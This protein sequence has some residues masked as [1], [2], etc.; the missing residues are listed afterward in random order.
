MAKAIESLTHAPSDASAHHSGR[1]GAEQAAP[2]EKKDRGA[3]EGRDAAVP[4]ADHQDPADTSEDQVVTSRRAAAG[5]DA[6]LPKAGLALSGGGVRSATF[7]FGL[8][9]AL[10]ANGVLQRFDYLSTV[11]GGGYAGAM[12]GRLFA[13]GASADEVARGLASDGS[14]LL[15]WLR[16]NGRYLIPSGLADMLQAGASQLRGFIATQFEASVVAL[17]VAALI[18]LPHLLMLALGWVGIASQWLQ[19]L[20]TLWWAA[21]PLP[22]CA[23]A[24]AIFTY[25]FSRDADDTGARDGLVAMG[26]SALAVLLAWRIGFPWRTEALSGTLVLLMGVAVLLACVPIAYLIRLCARG[27]PATARVVYTRWLARSLATIIA[28]LAFG[29]ADL[30]TWLAA[31]LWLYADQLDLSTGTGIVAVVVIVARAVLPVL[32]NR[33]LAGGGKLPL[34]KLANIAGLLLAALLALIWLT[35]LQ[36]FIFLAENSLAL[37]ALLAQ[38]SAVP[39]ARWIL[40]F[41]LLA[42][43]AVATL[44]NLAQLNRSSAHEFYRSRLARTYVSVGNYSGGG[45]GGDTDATARARFPASTLTDATGE[46]ADQT[47]RVTELLAGDDVTLGNYLPHRAG[48]PLHLVNCCIN[49][50]RDDR[51]GNYNADRKGIA[52]TV[53]ALGLETGTHFPMAAMALEKSALN[54]MS[55]AS[56]IA[57]SGAAASSGMGSST[58]PGTS[59]L[60]FL[61]GLRLGYW[62]QREP[63]RQ[64]GKYRALLSELFARFPGLKSKAWYL[65][66]GGHF[67]NTGVYALLK[68]RLPLIVLADC[69]ADPRYLFADLEN[70]VRKARLDY[71]AHIDFI[72]PS[73]LTHPGLRPL[74]GTPE[75]IGPDVGGAHLLLGRIRY[76]SGKLGALLVVKPRRLPDLPLDIV[77]YADRDPVFPQQTTGDQFFDEAQWESYQALGRLLG[78][79]ITP[80]LLAALPAWVAS[81]PATRIGSVAPGPTQAPPPSRRARLATTLGTSI[82]IGAIASM[83]LA[84][85]QLWGEHNRAAAEHQT[86][87]LD[88]STKTVQTIA[89]AQSVF[90][91][92]VRLQIDALLNLAATAPG[93][94]RARRRTLVMLADL[95]APVCTSQTASQDIFQNTPQSTGVCT[96]YLQALRGEQVE[97]GVLRKAVARYWA[98]PSAGPSKPQ[99]AA[100]LDIIG[101]MK[102][103]ILGAFE[104]RYTLL[105]APPPAGGPPAEQQ[106]AAPGVD[107]QRESSAQPSPQVACR[108]SA[109]TGLSL[110]IHIYDESERAAATA[111]ARTA[112]EQWGVA[113]PGIE[114]VTRAAQQRGRVPPTRWQKA[115]WLYRG[116]DGKRCAQTASDW[117]A[118]VAEREVQR[119]SQTVPLPAALDASPGIVE[120]WLPPAK[121]Q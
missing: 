3:A 58:R 116:D 65:S 106:A 61:S 19:F 72:E 82:G 104:S 109:Q 22:V 56:W 117:L 76:R 49:Q 94:E 37:Q 52:L 110:Y 23:A 29:L 111:I 54:N 33:Q 98:E 31:W 81:A 44:W 12:L 118:T 38:W 41:G 85:W 17:L 46:L 88:A 55:L 114:N 62:W 77:G 70:L 45:E 95:L 75:T 47:A 20:P 93:A 43:Y 120:L 84:G 83:V 40:V 103:K 87:F 69:G 102:A 63:G 11:S 15:W 26:A 35:L 32:Q 73:A 107:A 48:G 2:A 51:T 28:V 100:A 14:L 30:I 64:F 34:E 71:A 67:D 4:P 39:A 25:W 59:A 97:E 66:D 7:C 121:R 16:S 113:V 78:D 10:A 21:L 1:C 119:S 74:F 115:T 60:L 90:T 99:Y 53:S 108:S 68:R 36:A 112:V 79:S 42:L 57:I 24:I 8:L 13:R 5:I 96:A 101:R 86:A 6:R 18:V 92:Q 27:A 50:T 89:E 9:R 80:E 91:P 105:P